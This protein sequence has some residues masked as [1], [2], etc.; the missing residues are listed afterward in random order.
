MALG[1]KS[2]FSN[3]YKD[4]PILITHKKRILITT[5]APLILAS[6]ILTMLSFIHTPPSAIGSSPAMDEPT[7]AKATAVTATSLKQNSTGLTPLADLLQQQDHTIISRIYFSDTQQIGLLTSMVDVWQ[8]N[9]EEGYVVA[10]LS[11]SQSD[12]LYQQGFRIELDVERNQRQRELQSVATSVQS[13]QQN[14]GIPGFACYRTVEETYADMAALAADH[15]TLV[16][17]IDIGDSWNKVQYDAAISVTP[18]LTSTLPPGYDLHAAVL[19]NRD[20][21]PTFTTVATT[22]VTNTVT[23]APTS[24]GGLTTTTVITTFLPVTTT[25]VV[26]KP[27]FFL[28]ATVH[29]RELTPAETATRFA[30]QLVAGYSVDA[31][32]TW[33]L[34]YNEIH[35]VPLGNPDGRKFAEQLV[36]WR[37][38]VNTTDGCVDITSG[39]PSF[40][41]YGV[42][43]NRNASFMWNM[44][45]G[46]GCS[47]GDSCNITYRGS[48]PASEPETE[49]FEAYMRSIFA[50]QRG[51]LPTDSASLDTTGLMVSMHSYSELILYPW[52][53]TPSP[54]PNKAQLRT[55][56]NKF[57]YITGY[58]ACQSG[59]PGCI[60]PTD[61]TNDDWA[62][63]ELGIGAYTFELGTEFFESCDYFEE[64]LLDEIMPSLY[65]AAKSARLPYRLPAG[66]ET[67]D[68]ALR[69]PLTTPLIA[70]TVLTLTATADDTRYAS[71]DFGFNTWT[72]P[73]QTI[74]AVRYSIDAPAWIT[75]T[76]VYTMAAV[77]GLFASGVVSATALIETTGLANGKHTVFVESQDALGN[78][79]V[80]SAIDFALVEEVL[81]RRYFPF[82]PHIGME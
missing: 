15:P 60:Y 4:H 30:E 67:Y 75:G 56:A 66:P 27:K 76:E 77:N 37:K 12:Q 81:Y 79:G 29:A 73:T 57:G 47:S 50:D 39:E 16:S 33:L 7:G 64:R 63:G 82:V 61:G 14:R 19:T 42:D 59:A 13:A 43:L 38:N 11:P 32:I 53:F 35:I 44:C 2:I 70:G 71:N 54:P 9:H 45:D 28:L 10:Q 78:W 5:F 20:F 18:S 68:L 51:P 65:Y 46:F 41:I 24:T 26:P 40:P 17:W 25:T 74:N 1:A 49:A 72:E 69:A 8:I 48:G 31:D 62:Y 23:I 58:T 22:T 52:G 3:F 55:L 21:N 80:A 6:F 36:S 34:D